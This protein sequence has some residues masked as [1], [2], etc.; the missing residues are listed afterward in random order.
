MESPEMQPN[1][2]ADGEEPEVQ[3]TT[4]KYSQFSKVTGPGIQGVGLKDGNNVR[5]DLTT[6]AIATNPDVI[7]RDAKGRS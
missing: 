6:D 7:L 4:K 1:L 3:V 2:F 5:F